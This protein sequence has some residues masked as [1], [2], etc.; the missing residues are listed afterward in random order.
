MKVI[1]HMHKTCI[2]R[3]KCSHSKPHDII[4]L[5]SLMC[6]N[7]CILEHSRKDMVHGQVIE[8]KCGHEYLAIYQRKD[9]LLKLN[10]LD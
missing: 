6:A 8:C 3:D 4:S 7:N 2:Y 9:K 10:R 5:P 1:C